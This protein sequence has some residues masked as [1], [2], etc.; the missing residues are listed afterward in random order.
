MKG[1]Y[2][3][4]ISPQETYLA[5]SRIFAKEIILWSIDT[6]EIEKE[7]HGHES[8]THV[9]AF[10]EDEKHLASIGKDGEVK[11]WDVKSQ[12]LVGEHQVPLTNFHSLRF[13]GDAKV[14]VELDKGRRSVSVDYHRR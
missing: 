7:F 11:V 13:A 12:D 4:S 2:F 6:G 1:S 3:A 5:S 14:I 8:G 10:A 9:V